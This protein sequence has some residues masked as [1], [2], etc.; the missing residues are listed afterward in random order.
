MNR[1]DI[2][3]GKEP[4][5]PEKPS[6]NI[7][8]KKLP[9]I[10]PRP[11]R[12]VEGAQGLTGAQG[13]T[14]YQGPINVYED[15]VV[16]V[17]NSVGLTETGNNNEYPVLNIYYPPNTP[18]QNQGPTTQLFI[19]QGPNGHRVILPLRNLNYQINRD[20]LTVNLPHSQA[21]ALQQDIN[22]AAR[23]LNIPQS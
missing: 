20:Q 11:L 3:L 5:K 10:H 12:R 4:E 23:R 14:G 16:A 13:V 15:N 21:V 1:F 6:Q 7:F 18:I 8:T 2:L 22:Q 9:G 19:I 17:Y